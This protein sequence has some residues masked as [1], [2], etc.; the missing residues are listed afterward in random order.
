MTDSEAKF[1]RQLVVTLKEQRAK[2]DTVIVAIEGVLEFEE[3]VRITT[4]KDDDH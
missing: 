2:M 4:R 3:S 1:F